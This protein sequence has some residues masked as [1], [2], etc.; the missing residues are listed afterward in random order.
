VQEA[1]KEFQEELDYHKK[2]IQEKA[3]LRE[4]YEAMLTKVKAWQ[5]PTPDHVE[6][7]RF[8]EE[9]ITRS[10]DYDCSTKHM[11]APKLLSGREWL[12]A[13]IA[14][15]LKDI[16]RHKKEHAEEVVRVEGRN[17]WLKALRDSLNG[18]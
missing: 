17:S 7:K 12:N 9:Q 1:N 11:E 14:S 2:R 13:N 8:M 10:I 5:A 16:E 15:A 3:E 4:K 18:N 6:L